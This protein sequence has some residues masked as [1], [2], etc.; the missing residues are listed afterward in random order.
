MEVSGQL[1][2][3]LLIGQEAVWTPRLGLDAVVKRKNPFP[4]R[5]SN[6]D[7]AARRPDTILTEP[8]RLLVLE[9]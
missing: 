2:D 7:R 4:C 3:P 8:P 9:F 6:G 1:H 5:E